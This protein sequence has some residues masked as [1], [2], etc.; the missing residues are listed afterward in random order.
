VVLN[1]IPQMR[2]N[3]TAVYFFVPSDLSRA[4]KIGR[5]IIAAR[6][7]AGL[8]QAELATRTN[9]TQPTIARYENGLG[10][11]DVDLAKDIATV[12]GQDFKIFEV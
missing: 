4:Q 1:K 11:P 7:I 5:V 2:L 9:S 8:T 3:N 12:T 10:I 6:S